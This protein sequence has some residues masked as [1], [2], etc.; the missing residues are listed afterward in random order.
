MATQRPPKGP[1]YPPHIASFG[2]QPS[3][4]PDIPVCAVLLAIY[5]A[6][7]ITNM[8]IFQKNRRRNYKFLPTVFI[9][10]FCMSRVAA[11]VLRI[12]WATR[13]HNVRLSIA[14]SIL[15]N[16]GVLILYIVNLVFAQ[17]ILRALQPKIGWN[18]AVSIGLKVCYALILGV[19]VMVITASILS[20]YTLNM[21]TLKAVRDVTLAATTYL[22]VFDTFP[23]VLL[24]LAQFLPTSDEQETFG[25]GSM[26]KKKLIV[27][28]IGCLVVLQAGFKT[29]SAYMPA[30]PVTN[31]AWYQSKAAFYTFQFTIEIIIL[32][33]LTVTRP[34]RMFHVPNGSKKP[35][36]YSRL[37]LSESTENSV[38]GDS[39]T[40]QEEEDGA[41]RDVEMEK[42]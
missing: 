21:S 22:L 14:A 31:P 12:A 7:A 32:V 2:E 40:E 3:V 10:G 11:L 28:V 35:G 38:R 17:R 34:D 33:T 39:V 36:D 9:F 5:I 4:I 37:R 26:T 8:T 15:V 24:A 29:G 30:R 23:L 6:F 25:E 13:P 1:P 41:E 18:P 20:A 16:A 42:V 27:F 19:L